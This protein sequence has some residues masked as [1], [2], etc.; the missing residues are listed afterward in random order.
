MYIVSAGKVFNDIDAFGCA[1]AYTELLQKE[2][3]DAKTVF[4]GPLNH[5]VTRLALEQG[6]EYLTEYTPT[7]ED[8]FVYVDLSGPTH[9][10]FPEEDESKVFEI[11]D[12]HYG[13]EDYWRERIGDRAHIE[14]VGAAGT[15]IWEEFKK[16]GFADTISSTS[17]NVLALA[18]LQNTLNFTSSETNDRDLTAFR[19]LEPHVTMKT[20]WQQRY[21]DECA[22][23]M[24][25]HFEETL[26]NDTKIIENFFGDQPFVFSQLEITEDPQAFLD[27]NLS[28]INAY[29]SEF[30]NTRCLINIPDIISK[31]SL[32]YSNDPAW[33]H[34]NLAPRFPLILA[35]G[36]NS[37]LVPI[38][39]RKQITKLLQA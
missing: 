39:Q 15:L 5:S 6:A 9:F 19:E 24:Q 3:K 11:Y 13:F 37:I 16:R 26:R 17:A 38:H 18:I 23:G 7:D 27:K 33:L 12:H 22:T 25:N 20:G 34:E 35:T 10:A 30:I 14:R 4:I 32:L 1:V 36:E 28:A 8:R 21:F 2:G 31:T 29:W